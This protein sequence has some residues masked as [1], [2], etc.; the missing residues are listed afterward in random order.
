[1]QVIKLHRLDAHWG[2]RL[3]VAEDCDLCGRRLSVGAQG[4]LNVV[5]DHDHNHC[6]GGFSCGQ[7]VR[8]LIDPRCNALLGMLEAIEDVGMVLV[9]GYL[10]RYEERRASLP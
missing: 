10:A 3:I 9:Q 1:M 2:W 4:R 6:P 8:G 7:C 5:V